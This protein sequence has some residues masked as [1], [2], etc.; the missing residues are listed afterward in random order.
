MY[1]AIEV[2]KYLHVYMLAL[3]VIILMLLIHIFNKYI[4]KV[5]IISA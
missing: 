3:T 5:M 2:T 4:K 1:D